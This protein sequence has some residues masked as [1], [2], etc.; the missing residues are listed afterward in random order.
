[1]N[2]LIGYT[3]FVGSNISNQIKFD[4]LF[5]SKNIHEILNNS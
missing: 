4:F 3:G 1:M 5:N 2:A